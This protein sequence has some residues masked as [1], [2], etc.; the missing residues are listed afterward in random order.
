M[1]NSAKVLKYI[2][3]NLSYKTNFIEL[4][5]NEIMD[6]VKEFTLTEFSSFFPDKNSIT[7][8][9]EI[10][11]NKVPNKSNEYYIFD[12]DGLE[13]INIIG[14][15]PEMSEYLMAGYPPF[16]PL[17]FGDIATWAL[18]TEAAGWVH[19]FSSFKLVGEYKHPNILV[20]SPYDFTNR[21]VTV[22]YERIQ[23]VDFS[24]IPNEQQM[25]FMQLALA[26]IMIVIGRSRQKYA[27]GNLQTPFGNIPLSAGIF[28]EGV[29]SKKELIE[30]LKATQIPNVT[31]SFG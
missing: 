21:R 15:Y 30:Q 7:L 3:L 31:I 4:E 14:M 24:R 11:S 6:Y 25:I 26:D 16:G 20:V 19:K 23:P 18:E 13:I 27:D 12:P 17:G 9:L 28:D 8:D 10:P 22:E 29:N 1:L 2:K 5:D